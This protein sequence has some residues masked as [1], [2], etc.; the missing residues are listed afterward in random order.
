MEGRRHGD[1][2][3][4]TWWL[5]LG[6]RAGTPGPRQG[7]QPALALTVLSKSP[8]LPSFALTQGVTLQCSPLAP[9]DPSHC[10]ARNCRRHGRHRGDL[11]TLQGCPGGSVGLNSPQGHPLS[12]STTAELHRAQ[13]EPGESHKSSGYTRAFSLAVF[14][15]DTKFNFLGRALN[16]RLSLLGACDNPGTAPRPARGGGP[17]HPT[18]A[19]PVGARMGDDF[20]DVGGVPLGI[21]RLVVSLSQWN[22]TEGWFLNRVWG[23]GNPKLELLGLS[24]AGSPRGHQKVG[25]TPLRAFRGGTGMNAPK[26]TPQTPNPSPHSSRVAPPS[27]LNPLAEPPRGGDDAGAGG[28]RGHRRGGGSGRVPAPRRCCGAG[29][30]EISAGR[31]PRPGSQAPFSPPC[32]HPPERGPFSTPGGRGEARWDPPPPSGWMKGALC[33][34]SAR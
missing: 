14:D 10:R 16:P 26:I 18:A 6:H 3:H 17:Q 20:G 11:G 15:R 33:C 21:P 2:W 1:T 24:S 27:S 31:P 32:H 22:F 25:V 29:A 4:S 12:G 13:Q 5:P 9:S 28:P 34:G 7:A 30:A 19:Q 8:N 23:E